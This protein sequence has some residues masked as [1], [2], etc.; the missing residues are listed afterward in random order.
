MRPGRGAAGAAIGTTLRRWNLV[1]T[2][3]RPLIERIWGA[4]DQED[5]WQPLADRLAI[6]RAPQLGQGG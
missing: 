5:D 1:Q 3:V 2:S 4:N 6:T